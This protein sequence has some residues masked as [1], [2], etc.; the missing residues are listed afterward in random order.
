MNIMDVE[1]IQKI[2]PHRYPMLLLDRVL[3][4]DYEKQH[5][6]AVKAVSA[7]EPYMQGHFP[8]WKCMPGV[9]QLEAMAQACGVLMSSIFDQPGRIAYF[10]SI[11]KAKFRRVVRPGDLMRIE[12]NFLRARL[13][14]TRMKGV[15]T[16][17]GE[18][19]SEAEMMFT[20]R[21]E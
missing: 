11:D 8:N 18:V 2:L 9:L 10:L 15:V 19:A 5:I 3:E 13:R 1:A 14:V 6:V 21:E 4:C 20:Y 16:V 12:V 17:D 7:N